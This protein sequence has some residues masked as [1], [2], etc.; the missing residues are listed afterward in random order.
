MNLNSTLWNS[1]FF[2]LAVFLLSGCAV[3]PQTI[4][5]NPSVTVDQKNIG[6]GRSINLKVIDERSSKVLGSR[7]GIYSDTALLTIEGGPE[8][9]IRQ[10]VVGALSGYGFNVISSRNKDNADIDM[11]VVI[12]TLGYEMIGDKF[13]KVIKNNILLKAVCNKESEEFTSRYAANIE[14]EV[15]MTPLAAK[16]EKM[17]NNLVSKALSALVKDQKLL[18]FLK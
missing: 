15:L 7:G 11:T 2:V 12:E 14:E 6:Q 3:S 10:E 16:N 9:P 13:P 4:V 17:I 1:L 18:G 8:E 5:L